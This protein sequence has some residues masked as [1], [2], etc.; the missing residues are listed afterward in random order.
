MKRFPINRCCPVSGEPHSR[1]LTYLPAAVVG[2]ANPTYR[3]DFANI[4]GISPEDEFPIVES[5][6]GFVFSGWLPRDDFLRRVYEDVIDHSKTITETS[7]TV[8]R[9]W[10]SAAPLYKP[11]KDILSLPPGRCACLILAVDTEC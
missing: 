9:Y 3:P 7:N 2:A 1:V 8:A 11:S 5:P 10:S 6:S 4:L